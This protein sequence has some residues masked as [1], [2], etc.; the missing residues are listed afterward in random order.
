MHGAA[1]PHLTE[2]NRLL[3][4]GRAK[5][6]PHELLVSYRKATDEEFPPLLLAIGEL[7]DYEDH[8]GQDRDRE[9]P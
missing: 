4:H 5:R 8:S 7:F 1:P 2:G 6:G 9:P 3:G